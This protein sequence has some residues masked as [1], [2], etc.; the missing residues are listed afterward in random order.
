M[1]NNTDLPNPPVKLSDLENETAALRKTTADRLAAK[2]IYDRLV[3]IQFNGV[4]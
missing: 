3:V 2:S 1:S 4:G